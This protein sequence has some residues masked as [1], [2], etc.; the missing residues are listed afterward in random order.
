MLELQNLTL[1]VDGEKGRTEILKEINLTL[2]D[3]RMYVITGPN[4]SG[5]TSLVKTIMGIYR[6][7]AGRIIL[8][9]RDITDLGI[10]ERAKLGIGYA[11][12]QPPRFKGLK[13]RELLQLAAGT[14]LD[15]KSCGLLY[16]VGLCP[17]DYLEREVDASLSGGELKR[18]E[19]A[20]LLA[21][22]LHLAIYDEPEAGIDLWSFGRL[23]DTFR[24]LHRETTATYVIISHQERILEQADEII[25]MVDGMVKEMGRK[26][27]IWPQI[28]DDAAC[29]CG[30]DCVERRGQDAECYR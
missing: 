19:I 14:S 18:I 20:T 21:R 3:R 27:V 24:R 6:P 25:L 12:Q 29:A 7:T 4:G 13:I 17:S 10:A 23:T 11:F 5:K 28:M 9:G 1:A 15:E 16:E 30:L 2:Q 8:D 22:N 26:E